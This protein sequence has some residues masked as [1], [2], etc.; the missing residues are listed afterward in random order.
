[1]PK[2]KKILKNFTFKITRAPGELARTGEA[3]KRSFFGRLL[4]FARL[5]QSA[6][7]YSVSQPKKGLTAY[8]TSSPSSSHAHFLSSS[9]LVQDSDI[10]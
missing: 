1:M 3:I 8:Y 9:G 7:Q 5:F 6:R 2:S 10:N 4:C